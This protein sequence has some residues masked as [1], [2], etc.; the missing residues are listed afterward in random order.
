MYIWK[1]F[2][3][4]ALAAAMT[5]VLFTGCEMT[6]QSDANTLT[7]NFGLSNREEFTEALQDAFP[8]IHF[9]IE[10]YRGINVSGY[11][12]Q[13]LTHDDV[14]DIFV[15]NIEP[16]QADQ[17]KYLLDMSGFEFFS[18]YQ[19]NVL[20]QIENDGG[21]YI[22]PSSMILRT[23][24]YNKTLF[25]EKGWK[26]PTNHEELVALVEQIREESDITPISFSAQGAYFFTYITTLSQCGYLTTAR[27]K[28]WQERYLAGEASAE[29]GFAGGIALLQDLID[30]GAFDVE[31]YDNI[32]DKDVADLFAKNRDAAMM[33]VWGGQM[34][35]ADAA[36]ESE[37][38]IALFPFYGADEG[39]V[40]IGTASNGYF[41]MSK[42]LGE[43]GNEKKLEN[44]LRVMAWI[45]SR[46]GL[47]YLRSSAEDI[48]PLA[49]PVCTEPKGMYQDVWDQ[50]INGYKAT[51]LHTGYE[52]IM[53]YA[54]AFIRDKMISQGSLDGLTELIDEQHQI[55]LK[56]A[57]NYGEVAEDFTLEETA[58]LQADI[59]NGLGIAD[60]AMVSLGGAKHGISSGIFGSNGKL[61]AGKLTDETVGIVILG[62]KTVCTLSLTGEEIKQLL[63]KGKEIE[64]VSFCYYWSGIDVEMKGDKIRSIRYNGEELDPQK[65]YTVAFG[66]DDYPEKMGSAAV[67]TGLVYL[68]AFKQYMQENSPVEAP[69]VLRKR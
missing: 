5:V 21:V 54:G 41:G 67:E 23:M 56:N 49:V 43:K 46:E 55:S 62:G 31:K 29:E 22:L 66:K 69:E 28:D 32:L 8:D 6:K 44:A 17:K 2:M 12:N 42:R 10:Q 26:K 68:D 40:L 45:C 33:A 39:D 57:V 64:T 38:E 30:A 25:E 63:E 11:N 61:Y 53:L 47:P 35:L 18:N 59:L 15:T 20:S 48:C 7:M 13:K 36:K 34:N 37:D 14:P 3:A 58:Q 16:N 52:D 1:R 24:A 65:V 4:G 19:V 50:N 60:F 51:M 27:G 9:E